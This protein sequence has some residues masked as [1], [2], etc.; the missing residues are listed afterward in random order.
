MLAT[1]KFKTGDNIH[2]I[3]NPIT[4]AILGVIGYFILQNGHEWAW[5]ADGLWY[6][7]ATLFVIILAAISVG[8]FFGSIAI[9]NR[10][11]QICYAGLISFLSLS[12]FGRGF[13]MDMNDASW[14]VALACSSAFLF[15][16]LQQILKKPS[17]VAAMQCLTGTLAG[18]MIL[19]EFIS[20]VQFYF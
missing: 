9:K 15:L 16:V 19:T 12:F 14:W 20:F 18:L 3:F 17:I 7:L 13:R 5:E 1:E 11:T 6:L 10:Y 4:T 8:L 2:S